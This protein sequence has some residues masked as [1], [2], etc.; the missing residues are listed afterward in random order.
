MEDYYRISFKY[1]KILTDLQE[2]LQTLESEGKQQDKEEEEEVC[3]QP[4]QEH[5]NMLF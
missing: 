1:A 2:I 4:N 5:L 3:S